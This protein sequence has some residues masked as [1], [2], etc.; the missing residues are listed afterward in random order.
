MFKKIFPN[1]RVGVNALRSSYYSFVNQEAVLRGKILTMSQ[2]K[3]IA[4]K[5]R[6][7]VQYLD[8]NYL[9]TQQ[10]QPNPRLPLVK[11]EPVDENA[12]IR[13]KIT[14]TYQKQ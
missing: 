12:V 2:K 10:N 7:S 14:E 4:E 11:M 1:V 5:M 13:P 3:A 6:T 9:K 8:G